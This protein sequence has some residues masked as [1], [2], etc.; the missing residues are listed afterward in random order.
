LWKA[1]RYLELLI[2]FFFSH[3]LDL[4]DAINFFILKKK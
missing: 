3:W 4:L 2:I 1:L